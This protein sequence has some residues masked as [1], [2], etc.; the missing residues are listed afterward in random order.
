MLWERRKRKEK[1]GN[2]VNACLLKRTSTLVIRKK[3][4]REVTQKI[5]ERRTKKKNVREA[6]KRLPAQAKELPT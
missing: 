6:R 3:K 1:Y 2:Q 4:K 5:R